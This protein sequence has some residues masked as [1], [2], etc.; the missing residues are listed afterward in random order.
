MHWKV[1]GKPRME[2]TVKREDSGVASASSLFNRI[3]DVLAAEPGIVEIVNYGPEKPSV[4]T[5][6]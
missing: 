6:K 3:P 5:L 4:Q 2:I 1:L